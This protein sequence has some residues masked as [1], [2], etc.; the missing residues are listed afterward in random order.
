MLLLWLLGRLRSKMPTPSLGG[1]EPPVHKV[2]G[3]PRTSTTSESDF[4]TAWC[5][6]YSY[7]L[8]TPTTSAVPTVWDAFFH[9]PP[10][11]PPP[12]RHRRSSLWDVSATVPQER[13]ENGSEVHWGNPY[14]PDPP[15]QVAPPAAEP[16]IEDAFEKATKLSAIWSSCHKEGFRPDSTFEDDMS[17]PCS[18][19]PPVEEPA[20]AALANLRV[21]AEMPGAPESFT[22]SEYYSR[23]G[24]LSPCSPA[25]TE[26][27]GGREARF[28][29]ALTE[30]NYGRRGPSSPAP[31]EYF[32]DRQEWSPASTQIGAP[33]PEHGGQGLP[34]GFSPRFPPGVPSKLDD[35]LRQHNDCPPGM[36]PPDDS[37]AHRNWPHFFQDRNDI[38]EHCLEQCSAQWCGLFSS[39]C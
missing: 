10:P 39:C 1:R 7:E 2:A 4:Y 34:G 5:R 33:L 32:F 20:F 38:S 29:Q 36:P 3:D 25:P 28:S 18:S 6:M 9:P 24:P 27:Y 8:F 31:T 22:L 30:Y 15:A 12:P 26:N 37:T 11:P 21:Y 19:T 14:G 23:Q 17:D 16:V 13:P 35:L